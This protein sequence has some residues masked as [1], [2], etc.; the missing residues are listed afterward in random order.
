MKKGDRTRKKRNR[1]LEE[2]R[3]KSQVGGDGGKECR[4]GERGDFKGQKKQRRSY[5]TLGGD[6]W[7]SSGHW[8][9]QV[10]GKKKKLKKNDWSR[11]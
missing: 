1:D 5:S 2:R 11:L 6:W 8:A 3:K 10:R 7:S 4:R 9:G